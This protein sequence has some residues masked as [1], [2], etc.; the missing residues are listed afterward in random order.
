[1]SLG[2]KVSVCRITLVNVPYRNALIQ[3]SPK[4]NYSVSRLVPVMSS[5]HTIAV[6]VLLGVSACQTTLS[7]P[8]SLGF[9]N[10][11]KGPTNQDAVASVHINL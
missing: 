9:D 11:K 10:Y 8:S 4:I 7:S 5:D 2:V 1:M 3:G 6:F